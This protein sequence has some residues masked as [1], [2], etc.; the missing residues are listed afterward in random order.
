MPSMVVDLVRR[1][2]HS[3]WTH[4]QPAPPQVPVLT[5]RALQTLPME[6]VFTIHTS[7]ATGE[8]VSVKKS[9]LSQMWWQA[10]N[11]RAFRWAGWE[12]NDKTRIARVIAGPMEPLPYT[13][14]SPNEELYPE[15]CWMGHH[16]LLGD[17]QGWLEKTN[18]THLITHPSIL[19]GLD[20]S[21]LNLRGV[22]TQ[23]EKGSTNYSCQEAG[24]IGLQCPKNPDVQHIMENI[25][26][27]LVDGE[28]V[29]TD[30]TSRYLKRYALGDFA[31]WATCDCG[32]SL[33]AIKSI[34]GR[35][36]HRMRRP[37]GTTCFATFG[38][39]TLVTLGL[40]LRRYQM[41]QTAVDRFEFHV[42]SPPMDAAQVE[43]LISHLKVHIGFPCTI[44]VVY[45]GEFPPGKFEEFKWAGA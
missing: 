4:V 45:R 42:V 7:G 40:P 15:P 3:Q 2:E 33:L 19:A 6:G 14:W 16:P 34:V 10:M 39:P 23:G 29:V 41:I 28:V 11:I 35:T 27:E 44:S 36:R 5:R 31:E 20:L 8:P 17:I 9:A 18:P 37:D 32:R 30:T 12:L 13:Q 26:L 38:T 22:M 21:R 25:I 24:V 1:L 43:K